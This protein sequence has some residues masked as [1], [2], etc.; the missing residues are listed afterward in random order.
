VLES[1]PVA[2][3]I[4]LLRT[5][6]VALGTIRTIYSV[7]GRRALAASMGFL[8]AATFITAVGIVFQSPMDVV[9]MLGYATG[10]ALGTILGLSVVR[11]LSLGTTV[12][13]I[14]SPSGPIGLSEALSDAGFNITVFDGEGQ[15]GPI[16]L[17]MAVVEKRALGRLLAI[18]KPWLTRC[19]VTIGDAPLRLEPYPPASA[20]RK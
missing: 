6:D 12:V 11:H 9:K 8:E 10:F 20:I 7:E 15:A 4:A 14:I 3:L 5:V 2:L 16:R 17:I 1:L 18:A 19:F 13:R